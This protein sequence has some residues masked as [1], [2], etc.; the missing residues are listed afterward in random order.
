MNAFRT[1]FAGLLFFLL[2]HGL[3]AQESNNYFIGK[4]NLTIFGTPNGDITML[5]DFERKEGKLSGTLKADQDYS[6][7]AQEISGIEEKENSIILYFSIGGYDLD[8]QL[9][10][11]DDNNLTGNILGMFDVTGKR[12]V[13]EGQ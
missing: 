5:A 6:N 10:K 12:V 2:A 13:E 8:M 4:W 1:L 7:D 3:S 9:D 11:K